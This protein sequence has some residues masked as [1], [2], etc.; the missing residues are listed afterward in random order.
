MKVTYQNKVQKLV[1]TGMF[2]AL[3]AVLSLVSIPMPTGVP[4]TLQ[5]FAVALCGYV[6]GPAL[7]TL[8]VMV[9]LAMGA[10]GLPV[11]AGFSSGVGELLGMTGG[12]LWG[13]LFLALF[14]GLGVW[15]KKR[16]LALL[17]GAAGLAVCH[18]LGA[19]QFSLVSSSPLLQSFLL[20]SVPYLIKDAVSVALAYLAGTAVVLA[21]KKAKLVRAE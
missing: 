13:F 8:S 7:G 17:L 10:V 19:L 11:F 12:F 2:S 18:L 4:I 6:L 15:T 16:P 3:L 21:L 5:T 1:M 14:C 9:Y 20:V